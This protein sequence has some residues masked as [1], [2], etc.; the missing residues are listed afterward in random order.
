MTPDAQPLR[1]AFRRPSVIASSI[2]LLS[3]VL[4]SL[5]APVIAPYD[6]NE[7]G[8]D[9]QAP[10]SKKHWL[11]TDLV[12]RDVFSRLLYGSR[13]S[14]MVGFLSVGLYCL[15]GA[16]IGV[17][18][19]AFPRTWDRILSRLADLVLAFP[20]LVLI[21]ATV[22]LVGPGI[23]QVI[24]LLGLLG[25]P[26]VFRVVRGNLLALRE[27]TMVE[28]ARALGA[29]GWHI[30]RRYLMP[31]ATGAIVVAFTF[32]VG[33]VILT[34]AVLSFLGLG[35]QPPTASWGNM[36][37]DA[38]SIAVLEQMPW[39]WLAPG[40]MILATV[41]S[42]HIIGDALREALDPRSSA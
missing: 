33:Q 2:F 19:A 28:A 38:Q 1:R 25:W 20:P 7:I 31:S 16:L 29:S 12:G 17:I 37:T 24:W 41:I 14:L 11:G 21:L 40:V 9:F 8:I 34:E 13:I 10:P 5:L 4:V 30:A 23:G 42:V 36:L 35:V 39:L 18:A 3:L 26:S 15:I 32:G 6:P 27:S 22:S